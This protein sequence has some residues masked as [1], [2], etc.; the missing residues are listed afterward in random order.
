[1]TSNIESER[2]NRN[3]VE[4]EIEV[5]EM[6]EGKSVAEEKKM[7]KEIETDIQK[8]IQKMRRGNGAEGCINKQ[9]KR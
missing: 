4:I 7:I 8:L 1:M 3:L 2:E 5:P 6:V 9:K